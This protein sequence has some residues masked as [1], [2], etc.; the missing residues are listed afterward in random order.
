MKNTNAINVLLITC[1]ASFCIFPKDLHAFQS[2]IRK[3]SSIFTS[4]FS[5]YPLGVTEGH[6]EP[7]NCINK[8]AEE[9]VFESEVQVP[10]GLNDVSLLSQSNRKHRSGFISLIGAPNMGKSTLLNSLISYNLCAVTPRP[11]TT[12]H[13][14][15]GLLTS[16]NNDQFCQLCFWD[17]PGVIR[18][19]AYKLQE[20]MMEAVKG[21]Y[22]D[23]DVILVVVDVFATIIPDD[24]LF[25]RVQESDKTVIVALNKI[26]LAGDEEEDSNNDI[27]DNL[28][29]SADDSRREKKHT[30]ALRISSAIKKLRALLPNA[31]AI[32][33]VTASNGGY[34]EGVVAL[35]TLLMGGPDVPRAFRELGRPISGMFLPGVNFI[36]N[37]EARRIVP[38]GPRLYG[39]EALTDRS[40]RFFAAEIIR[41]S[42]FLN[43]GK[44]LPYSCEVRIS[45]FR[46]PRPYDKKKLTRIAADICVDRDSQKGMV[47]G[48]NGQKIKDIGVNARKKLE[49]F[50]QGKVHLNLNVKVDKNWRKDENKLKAYGYLKR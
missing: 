6:Q 44:E 28:N 2:A 3:H 21:A 8:A 43:L 31:M 25:Q 39:S 24:E 32:I 14:I 5:T 29:E 50:L 19:P 13:S 12:R 33:P 35:R 48:R 15:L 26:D 45:D 16:P 34:D 17:T 30:S 10:D 38:V 41:A 37:E 20:G 49:E 11:Q 7:V 27:L 42:L 22:R 18:D 46:E 1:F 4:T 47:V 40:E 23:S 9:G 36:S